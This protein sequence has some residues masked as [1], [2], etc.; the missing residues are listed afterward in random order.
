MKIMV[1]YVVCDEQVC[2]SVCIGVW[3]LH[4]FKRNDGT[5]LFLPRIK[6][7]NV[8]PWG[9]LLCKYSL[10]LD[11]LG[12]THRGLLVSH[13]QTK[14]FRSTKPEH[15]ICYTSRDKRHVC[16][17]QENHDNIITL[18]IFDVLSLHSTLKKDFLQLFLRPAQHNRMNLWPSGKDYWPMS[19]PDLRE[20]E[21]WMIL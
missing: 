12:H 8:F 19:N 15:E 20:W 4:L 10:S 1:V 18:G 17:Q 21:H 3:S 2:L 7:K 5:C 14:C 11:L 16:A 13:R 9:F 6:W